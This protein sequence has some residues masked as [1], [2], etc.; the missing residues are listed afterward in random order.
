MH[1]HFGGLGMVAYAIEDYEGATGYL[2]QAIAI[3]P[4][5]VNGYAQLGW[6]F[7]VQ[8]QYEQALPNFERAIELEKDRS[9]LAQY[10]HAVGWVHLQR[11]AVPQS[12]VAFEKALEALAR[13]CRCPR[14]AEDAW[15][16]GPL[17]LV[18]SPVLLISDP[19]A[20]HPAGL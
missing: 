17:S 16:S 19:A 10:L 7:Y 6:V 13:P 5:Y 12:R 11:A 3:D 8:K 4:R 18:L 14:R 2:R 1:A 20:L 9:R 15:K